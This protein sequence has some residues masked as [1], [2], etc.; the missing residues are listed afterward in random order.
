[1]GCRISVASSASGGCTDRSR[2]L[3]CPASISAAPSSV[4]RSAML[5]YGT[6]SGSC[7]V[8]STCAVFVLQARIHPSALEAHNTLRSAEVMESTAA[9]LRGLGEEWTTWFRIGEKRTSMPVDSPSAMTCIGGAD[10]LL[11]LRFFRF[12]FAFGAP[13]P[14]SESISIHVTAVIRPLS[15][16]Y[17]AMDFW[18]VVS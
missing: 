14:D 11:W 16:T 3:W 6:W 9:E 5:E 1:M 4:F 10:S 18:L 15:E 12:R 8:P 7:Q 2:M 17:S 13:A